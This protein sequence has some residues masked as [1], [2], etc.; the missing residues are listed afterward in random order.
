V[1]RLQ[2]PAFSF[3]CSGL[4]PELSGVSMALH[5]QVYAQFSL[6]NGN[7]QLIGTAIAS[8]KAA[9]TSLPFW[10]YEHTCLTISLIFPTLKNA[11]AYIAYLEGVYPHSPAPP[12]VLDGNQQELF[13]ELSL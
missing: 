13:K 9:C 1:A 5:F 12:P 11:L 7:A 6:T 8:T 3:I 4:A 2:P 10:P